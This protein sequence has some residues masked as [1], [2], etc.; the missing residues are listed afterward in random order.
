[1]KKIKVVY[2]I[3]GVIDDEFETEIT[4]QNTIEN[5]EGAC[6]ENTLQYLE[7]YGGLYGLPYEEDF[8]S[9]E[10]YMEEAESWFD[11]HYEEV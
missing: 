4:E 6:F 5:I 10:E 2:G 1:M 9:W 7:S 3:A 11:F 8:E